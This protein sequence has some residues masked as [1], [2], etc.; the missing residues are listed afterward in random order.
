MSYIRTI[1]YTAIILLLCTYVSFAEETIP[2]FRVKLDILGDKDIKPTVGRYLSRELRNLGVVT[3]VDS[4]EDYILICSIKK[5]SLESGGEEGFALSVVF[6]EKQ[7]VDGVF[8]VRDEMWELMLSIENLP[9][10]KQRQRLL[11]KITALQLHMNRIR[12]SIGDYSMQLSVLS[13][14]ALAELDAK[15]K[16]IIFDIDNDYLKEKRKELSFI[17]K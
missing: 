9:N 16:K 7:D 11:N 4:A 10:T 2:D 14:G 17:S 13:I 6:C 8:A 5:I 3:I 12:N 1:I 15:C